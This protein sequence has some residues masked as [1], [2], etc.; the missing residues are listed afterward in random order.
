LAFFA[1]TVSC[2]CQPLQLFQIFQS[3]NVVSDFPTLEAVVICVLGLKLCDSSIDRFGIAQ[4]LF[5]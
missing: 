3:L 1:Q 2:L 4:Q 5:A